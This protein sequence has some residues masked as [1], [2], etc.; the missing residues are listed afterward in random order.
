MITLSILQLNDEIVLFAFLNTF[1]CIFTLCSCVCIIVDIRCTIPDFFSC[2]CP[3]DATWPPF[4]YLSIVDDNRE[5]MFVNRRMS[6]LHGSLPLV[7]G[8]TGRRNV[9]YIMF[10]LQRKYVLSNALTGVLVMIGNVV[11]WRRITVLGVFSIFI[12]LNNGKWYD[13]LLKVTRFIWTNYAFCEL[14]T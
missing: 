3:S 8:C 11:M 14:Y 4:G 5:E 13:A 2:P 6:W 12:T 1:F 7:Y 9:S 10:G